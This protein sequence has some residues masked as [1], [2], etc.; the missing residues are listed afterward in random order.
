MKSLHLPD[1]KKYA[2][3]VPQPGAVEAQDMIELGGYVRDVFRLNAE[4]K[5]FRIF[6]PD[7][8]MSNRLGKVFEETNRQW[9]ADLTDRDEFLAPN[10]RV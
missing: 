4:E 10:G 7:E 1:F 2:V 5:N 3:D 9:Q 8:T 6:G